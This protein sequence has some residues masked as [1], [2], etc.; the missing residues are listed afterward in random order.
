M[1]LGVVHFYT[2]TSPRA[3]L[4]RTCS[5][6]FISHAMQINKSGCLVMICWVLAFI[7]YMY[8]RITKTMDLGQYLAYGIYVL[9]VEVSTSL[10]HAC[11]HGKSPVP[12]SPFIECFP[13]AAACRWL[14]V[15]STTFAQLSTCD[16]GPAQSNHCAV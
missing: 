13:P 2:S 1:R 14:G 4:L 7:F 16:A 15:L 5:T 9:V 10:V 6:M 3:L 12:Q 8:I 11:H